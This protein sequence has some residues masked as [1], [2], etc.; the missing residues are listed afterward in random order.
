[1]TSLNFTTE[2]ESKRIGEDV[3][4]ECRATGVPTPAVTWRM[5][6][7]AVLI[8]SSGIIIITSPDLLGG[9]SSVLSVLTV[10]G[11]DASDGGEYGCTAMNL[12]GSDTLSIELSLLSEQPQPHIHT[13]AM[14][15][16]I[17]TVCSL[18][19]CPQRRCSLYFSS[20]SSYSELCRGR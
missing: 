12:V 11:S 5:D 14:N 10:V 9:D 17:Y 1:M 6:G 20:T 13:V 3:V 15:L 18:P 8:N 2:V 7:G 16:I 19:T 4:I